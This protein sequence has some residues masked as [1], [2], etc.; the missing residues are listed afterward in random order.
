MAAI[1]TAVLLS[2]HAVNDI[3]LAELLI[4]FAQ[5]ERAVVGSG[6]SLSGVTF[7]RLIIVLEE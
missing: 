7:H 1:S 2:T 3:L 6:D 4:P 5:S